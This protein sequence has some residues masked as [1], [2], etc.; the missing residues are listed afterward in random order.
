MFTFLSIRR[1]STIAA[2]IN[3]RIKRSRPLPPNETIGGTF[4]LRS[5][6]SLMS[7]HR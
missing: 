2:K 5:H 3:D 1:F 4:L 6:H 7:S